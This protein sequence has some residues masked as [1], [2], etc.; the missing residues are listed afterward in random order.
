M[1]NFPPVSDFLTYFRKNSQTP[2]KIFPILP[3]PEKFLDFHPT[4]FLITFFNHGLQILN[5]P[6]PIFSASLYFSPVS[7]KLLF[8]RYFYKFLPLFSGNLRVFHTLC[9][10]RFPLL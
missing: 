1:M 6:H 9:V 4:K 10:F 5:F 8:P 3:F 7:R 2:W